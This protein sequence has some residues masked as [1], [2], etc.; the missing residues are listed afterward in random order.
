MDMV[1][2]ASPLILL[3]KVGRVELLRRLCRMVCVPEDVVAEISK[4]FLMTPPAAQLTPATGCGAS[5]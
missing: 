5:P 2:N 4:L 1:V 3:C